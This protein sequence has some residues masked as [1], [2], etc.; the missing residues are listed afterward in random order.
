VDLDLAFVAKVV[1][2]GQTGLRYAREQGVRKALLKDPAT[3]AWE[4]LLG[5]ERK[6]SKLPTIQLLGHK[7]GI[8][9]EVPDVSELTLPEL[10]EDL[11]ERFLHER[12]TGVL[13][14]SKKALD[15][16]EPRKAYD[17]LESALKKIREEGIG[18][19]DKIIDLADLSEEVIERY[20]LV[21]TGGIIGVP[22][23]W[24]GM[25]ELTLGWQPEDVVVFVARQGIGK[26][27]TLLICAN[28]AYE[29]GKKVLFFVTEMSRLAIATRLH[30]LRAQMAYQLVRKG[31]LGDFVEEKFY[32]SVR[33]IERDGRFKIA[34]G[35]YTVDIADIETY[36]EQE[37]PDLVIVDGLYLVKDRTAPINISKFE[38]VGNAI[39]SLKAF[40]KRSRKPF[41]T[42]TQFNRKVSDQKE[43][44]A[45]I[46]KIGLSDVVGW[47]VDYAFALV[48]T[49]KLR[50]AKQM[51]V[52]SLK[53]REDQRA[54][55]TLNWDFDY[56]NFSQMEV[57]FE[58]D[59]VEDDDTEAGEENVGNGA[60][61][62]IRI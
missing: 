28:A 6:F 15:D 26:T 13:D 59:A 16:Y 34:G 53:V 37:D 9:I 42:S 46:E 11:N 21:K 12:L 50:A 5:H 30:S 33:S 47:T 41:L 2:E 36:V 58:S 57:E 56:M 27:W 4:L 35:K 61:K 39:E 40:G 49:K 14:S 20:K 7:M 25:D 19:D 52:K 43:E 10:V 54:T 3:K 48:Q 51:R 1:S 29:A 44:S 24:E 60:G 8:E 55:L 32:E 17:K 23:P 62:D 45:T 18:G 22:T 31:R 38:K